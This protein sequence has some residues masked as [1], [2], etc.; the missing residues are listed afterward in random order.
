MRD[1]G[2]VNGL[3]D[4]ID[5]LDTGFVNFYW[6]RFGTGKENV[7]QD[8][9]DRSSGCGFLVRKERECKRDQDPF[10]QTLYYGLIA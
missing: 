3:R 10:F 6:H 7:I 9:D 1:S 5:T 2:N 8:S 4:L